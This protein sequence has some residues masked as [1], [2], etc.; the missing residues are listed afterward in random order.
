VAGDVDIALCSVIDVLRSP[1]PVRMVPVGMLG[2]GGR[3]LTVRLYARRPW[4]EVRTVAADTDSHTSRALAELILRKRF[5][6]DPTM[7]DFD[8]ASGARDPGTDAML[9]IGDKVIN[10]APAT[11]RWPQQLDL[12]EEWNAWTGLPFVFATWL[13]RVDSDEEA[14]ARIRTAARVLDHQ[15]RHNKERIDGIIAREAAAHGWPVDLARHYL[16]DLLRF[17]FDESARAGLDRFLQECRAAGLAPA[18]SDRAVHADF[19]W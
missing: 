15:R 19:P 12:G 17:D 14:S 7:I 1:V 18:A 13:V 11:D 3:T 8:H 10:D 5:G 2:C 6:A 9:L 16:V 4:A